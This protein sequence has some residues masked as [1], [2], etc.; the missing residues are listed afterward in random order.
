MALKIKVTMPDFPKG[1]TFGIN[2][3]GIF[4]NGKE[5]EVTPE[6]EMAYVTQFGMPVREGVSG[7]SNIEVSG[8]ATVKTSDIPQVEDAVFVEDPAGLEVIEE[9]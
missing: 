1:T 3:L 8:T 2:G 9:K 5:R 6:E 4:E 7:S